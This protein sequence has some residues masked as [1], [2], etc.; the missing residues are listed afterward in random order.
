MNMP[1]RKQAQKWANALRSGE[2]KQTLRHLQNEGGYCC[3]G[4]ACKIFIPKNKQQIYHNGELSGSVPA[5]QPNAPEWLVEVSGATQELIGTSLMSANDIK[6]YD[7]NEI[8]D[9]IELL[10]VHEAIKPGDP[11]SNVVEN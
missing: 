6:G 7:F 8:A 2:F 4:V 10:Y 5:S 11:V 3:L 9:I 1:T